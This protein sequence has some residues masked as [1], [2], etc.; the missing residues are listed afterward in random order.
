MAAGALLILEAGGLVSD[1]S[2]GPDYLTTGHILTGNPK[3]YE[4]MFR[5]IRPH[6]PPEFAAR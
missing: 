4:E 3:I 2:G 6:L 1:L 5:Q